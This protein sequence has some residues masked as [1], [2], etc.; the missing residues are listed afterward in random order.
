MNTSLKLFSFVYLRIAED[1]DYLDI[2]YQLNE[3]IRSSTTHVVSVL[4]MKM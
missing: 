4:E 2:I 1:E 3:T